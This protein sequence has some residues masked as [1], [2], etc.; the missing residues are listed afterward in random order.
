[1]KHLKLFFYLISFSLVFTACGVDDDDNGG[2][3]NGGYQPKV[4]NS[5]ANDARNNKHL[6]R[7]EFPKIKGGSNNV[8]IVHQASFGVNYCVEWDTD[9][10]AQRWSCFQWHD[11][12]SDMSTQR[13]PNEK[14]GDFTEYPHDPDLPSKYYFTVDPYTSSGFD[15]GH[16]MASADRSYSY[17]QLANRQTFYMTNMQPQRNAF[18]TGVWLNMENTV[19]SWNSKKSKAT[20][21]DTLYIVKGGTID[22]ESN[23][24]YFDYN[25]S[26]VDRKYIGSGVNKIPVPKYFYMAILCK[27]SKGYK[28]MAFWVEHKESNDSDLKKYVINIDELEKKT[29]IDFFCNLPDDI[30][31]AVEKVPASQLITNFGLE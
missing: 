10:H 12:N 13:K 4:G 9:K 22:S 31:D 27:N 17:N 20:Q 6:A 24:G 21:R 18:N 28:A 8:I 5:N 3:G 16:I 7:Y 25:G 11:G 29:G 30:E 23:L 15:H 1:M 26:Y 14:N 19:H 2:G